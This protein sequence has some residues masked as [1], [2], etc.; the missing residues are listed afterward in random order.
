[1]KRKS[2]RERLRSERPGFSRSSS[3]CLVPRFAIRKD[4]PEI[5]PQSKAHG[6]YPNGM[7][8]YYTYNQA[9]TA[10]G[11]EYK[12]LTH[13]TEN[14]VLFNDTIVPS[15]HGETMKQTSTLS[16]EPSYTYDAA[17]RLTQ[18]QEIPA[19]EGCTTRIYAYEENSNR[20]TLTSRA[21]GSEGKCASEGGSSEWHTYDTAGRLTDPNITYETFGNITTAGGHRA[22]RAKACNRTNGPH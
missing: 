17:G 22:E 12:K 4:R 1:V 20:T 10:T 13:C 3:R 6:R 15:V 7:T 2:G 21:P 5:I 8:A 18:V 9:G 14:C 16:E 11:L 19:G